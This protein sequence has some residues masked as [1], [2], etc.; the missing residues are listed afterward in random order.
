[1]LI[2]VWQSAERALGAARLSVK[3]TVRRMVTGQV[4]IVTSACILAG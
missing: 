1:M 3:D 4:R 2:V